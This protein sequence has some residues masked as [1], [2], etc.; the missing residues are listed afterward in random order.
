MFI[1]GAEE[2]ELLLFELGAQ[3][4]GLPSRD[5]VE[6]LRAVAVAP[7]PQGPRVVLG[8]MNLR[9]RVVPVFD[10]RERFGKPSL[11]IEPS[12]H[13]IVAQAAKRVVALRADRVLDLVRLRA[14]AIEQV[15]RVVSGMRHITGIG[16]L[17][18]GV[19]FI[20]D[21]HSFLSEAETA[22]LDWALS[23]QTVAP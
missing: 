11:P 20:H 9:G 15:E 16:R 5:V 19:V 8:V 6:L 14:D 21:L 18:D 7:L 12:D 10:L 13:F 2:V 4:Y 17:S 1:R 23:N 22:T 3:R